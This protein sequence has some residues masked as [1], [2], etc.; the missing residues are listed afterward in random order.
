[1]FE[2]FDQVTLSHSE[3]WRLLVVFTIRS[4]FTSYWGKL[5]WHTRMKRWKSYRYSQSHCLL[6]ELVFSFSCLRMC[7][8]N[9]MKCFYS[10]RII[11]PL[12]IFK[13]KTT[14]PPSIMYLFMQNSD[15]KGLH[16]PATMMLWKFQSNH[17]INDVQASFRSHKTWRWSN[18]SG[19]LHFPNLEVWCAKGSR[20]HS[21][22]HMTTSD[23]RMGSGFLA[24]CELLEDLKKN[25]HC[26]HENFISN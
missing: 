15:I 6:F 17:L 5:F 4:K 25:L 7:V 8:G 26:G 24:K 16:I 1:M 13:P 10:L 23:L 3:C 14:S 9:L 11:A 20:E 2:E 21:S 19:S 22:T 12:Q 18:T